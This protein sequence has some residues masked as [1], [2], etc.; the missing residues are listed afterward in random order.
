MTI[1][2]FVYRYTSDN[3]I[4][5]KRPLS[6]DSQNFTL[7]VPQGYKLDLRT[8]PW[9][10]RSLAHKDSYLQA[11]VLKSYTKG[12]FG[13]LSECD[14]DELFDEALSLAGASLVTKAVLKYL[15]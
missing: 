2:D 5:L 11:F 3:T 14:A 6:F 4:K 8:L 12:G 15:Y 1:S 9:L 13:G 7:V 10:A